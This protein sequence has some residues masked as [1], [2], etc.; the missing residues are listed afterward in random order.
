MTA[1]EGQDPVTSFES[2]SSGPVGDPAL[3]AAA[4]DDPEAFGELYLQFLGPVYRYLLAR[5]GNPV[6]AEDLAQETFLRAFRAL[7][8]GRWRGQPLLPWL[9]AIARNAVV[10]RYRR[11]TSEVAG[12]RRL[13]PPAPLRWET[14][15]DRLFVEQLLERLSPEKRDLLALRFAAGLSTAEI[16]E[17]V[18][19]SEGAVRKQLFR[20]VREL[21]EAYHATE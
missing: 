11:T 10:D 8:H 3:V 19:K 15:E 6:D 1:T 7:R 2:T 18:G 20:I 17:L 5:T 13:S 16:A 12:V 9:L 14:V 4:T 21:R